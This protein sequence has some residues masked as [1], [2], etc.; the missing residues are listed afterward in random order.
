[1]VAAG[2][3]AF[4]AD[5]L[6]AVV[7]A[8]GVF[9]PVTLPDDAVLK[10]LPAVQLDGQDR[11]LVPPD[12]AL[13]DHKVKAASVKEAGAGYIVTKYLGNRD[14]LPDGVFVSGGEDGR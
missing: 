11:K 10:M 12:S 6:E 1:M 14:F 7:A 4:Y 8:D 3:G 9:A 2:V 13:V 5:E